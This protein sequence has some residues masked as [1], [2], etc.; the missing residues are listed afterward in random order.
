M[1]R[2][3]LPL[4]AVSLCTSTLRF[5]RSPT[6]GCGA[7]CAGAC[8]AA[9]AHSTAAAAQTAHVRRELIAAAPLWRAAE[10]LCRAAQL[11]ELAPYRRV[12]QRG[13]RRIG[14]RVPRE[15]RR[16]PRLRS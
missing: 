8:C 2:V 5:V 16:P 6:V 3:L 4:A 12:A 15:A 7:L 10:L 1:A 9:P 13:R 11:P 14:Q